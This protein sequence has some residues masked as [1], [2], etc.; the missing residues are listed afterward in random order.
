MTFGTGHGSPPDI[1]CRDSSMP[2]GLG[3]LISNRIT[4]RFPAGREAKALFATR[5]VARLYSVPSHRD[6]TGEVVLPEYRS[7][8]LHVFGIVFDNEN[9]SGVVHMSMVL[10]IKYMSAFGNYKQCPL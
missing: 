4:A 7:G 8:H 3:I 10:Q 6:F 1:I 5:A 9:P 2:S